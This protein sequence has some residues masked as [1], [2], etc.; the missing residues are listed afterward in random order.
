MD[1]EKQNVFEWQLQSGIGNDCFLMENGK[2]LALLQA[3]DPAI[4]FGG[5]GGK[6]QIINPDFTVEWE[7]MLST[8]SEIAHHDIEMLPNGNILA[9]VW[10]RI[11]AQE[12]QEAGFKE[13]YEIFPEKIVEIDP[14]TNERVW[15]WNSWDHLIQDF[16]STKNNF[17]SIAANPSK[18]DINYSLVPN[19]DIMHANGIDYDPKNDLIFLSVNFFSEV[20]V[21]DHSTTTEKA[22]TSSGGNFGKGGD[23]VYRFG[24]PEA[25][26]NTNG[27]RLFHNN[28]RP[29]IFME[30]GQNR[31]LIFMNGNNIEQS[32][33]YKFDLESLRELEAMKDNEPN[34]LWEFTHP[35]LYSP[36]VSGAE[37]LPNGNILITVGTKGIW[38]VT[39]K[40]EV[41]WKFEERGFWWR[42][43]P[44]HKESQAIRNLNIN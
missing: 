40:A 5:Y 3:E 2:L 43:Y 15:E 4:E 27:K 35:D 12:A 9:I 13:G 36:K 8:E 22:K 28:H 17:G 7:Y 30:N 41:V 23:L 25:Y 29:N 42:T 37:T 18:I 44:Y 34:V 38:E 33:V 1:K 11:S 39:P 24:N 31:M 20:W 6:L 14:G 26:Q 21:I 10:A 16:D 19:G 32:T